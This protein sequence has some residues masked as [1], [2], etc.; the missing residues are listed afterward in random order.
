MQLPFPCPLSHKC[1]GGV[2]LKADSPYRASSLVNHR[3]GDRYDSRRARPSA[4]IGLE[5]GKSHRTGER[6]K[7]KLS[8]RRRKR[9]EV[10]R[11]FGCWRNFW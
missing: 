6:M 9:T 4:C 7:S 11:A 5:D 3:L 10:R 8:I 1:D 2:N